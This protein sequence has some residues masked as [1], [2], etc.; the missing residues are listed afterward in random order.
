M[1]IAI[2]ARKAGKS[3]I[4]VYI[5]NL[6]TELAL[7]DGKNDYIVLINSDS[8]ISSF[9]TW[10]ANIC[11]VTMKSRIFSL[12]E[13]LELP[14]KL[15]REK[16][17]V[18]HSTH[19]CL[20]FIK[21]VRSVVTIHDLM[22]IIF[23]R[24]YPIAKRLF[25]RLMI[26]YAVRR[27]DLLIAVSEY[28]KSDIVRIFKGI[29]K[30]KIRVIPQASDYKKANFEAEQVLAQHQLKPGQYYLYV[31]SDKYN[32]NL[33]RLLAAYDQLK[34]PCPYPLVLAGKINYSTLK[35]ENIRLT[36]VI[37][38]AELDCLY[39]NARV[40]VMPSLYEGFGIPVIEAMTAGVPVVTANV[41]STAEIAGDAAWLVDPYNIKEIAAALIE[42]AENKEK[43]KSFIIKGLQRAD[44]FSWKRTASETLKAYYETVNTTGDN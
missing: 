29:S 9:R 15:Q 31:G 43:R 1:R 17:D 3:G 10:P 5:N 32:K 6:L 30:E 44:K 42:A 23:C 4:G 36:G 37:S 8:D 14:L 35:N 22:P 18:F 20:P 27:A 19:F 2:D 26:E 24:E 41:T 11:F 16:V 34:K 13:Q 7:Q 12:G 21:N 25:L 40:F 28:T 38:K 33:N 39:E